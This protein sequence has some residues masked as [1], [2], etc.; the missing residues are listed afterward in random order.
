MVD[1]YFKNSAESI[2]RFHELHTQHLRYISFSHFLPPSE[3]F[4][5]C[6]Y[7]S[8]ELSTSPYRSP[9][10]LQMTYSKSRKRCHYGSSLIR[11][12]THVRQKAMRQSNMQLQNPEH[13]WLAKGGRPELTQPPGSQTPMTQGIPKYCSDSFSIRAI[14]L[15][16]RNIL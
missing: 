16:K 3:I 15:R 12:C 5:P 8:P 7:I 13:D 2:S 6:F 1:E 9:A 14:Y 4:S 11:N 10:R